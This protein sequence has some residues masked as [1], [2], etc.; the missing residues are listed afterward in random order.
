MMN[1]TEAALLVR[2]HLRI[3][4]GIFPNISFETI[5]IVGLVFMFGSIAVFLLSAV[6]LCIYHIQTGK[7]ISLL[8]FKICAMYWVLGV[9]MASIGW[10][11]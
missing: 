9:V 11:L 4:P 5:G 10:F 6:H 7:P 2:E 1:A 8:C 3:V